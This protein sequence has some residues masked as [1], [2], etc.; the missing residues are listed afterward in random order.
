MRVVVIG[1]GP[2]GTRCA[3][4]VSCLPGAVVTLLGEE[5]G[6]P[7]DRVALSKY[8]AGDIAADELITHDGAALREAGIDHRPGLRAT[9]IDRD[10]RVVHTQDGSVLPYDKLVLALGAT[11]VR[12]PMPGIDLPGVLAYR[13]R[14]DVDAMLRAAQSGGAAVVIGG[15][16]LGLEAAAGLARRGM[17]VTVL[18]AVDRLMERQLDPGAAARLRAHLQTL[19]VA[20]LLAARS[21]RI[22]GT[23]RAA[24]V[25]LADGARIAADIVVLA[26]GIRPRVDLAREAMLEIGRGILVDDAMRSSDPAILAIGECA[27]HAGQCCGLVAPALAQAEI[28]ARTLAGEVA[29]YAPSADATALKVAGAPVFSAGEIEAADADPIVLDD[30]GGDYRRLLLRNDRL[31]GAILWGDTADAGFYRDLIERGAVLGTMRAALPFGRA[32]LPDEVVP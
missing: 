31:V 26:V 13:T 15:G 6:L 19:G 23:D 8:L 5:P 4:R 1:A 28:A 12:L 11:A 16:L 2:A 32:F 30:P 24:A 7:Y 10:A 29:C 3:E 17:R 14:E 18:H 22:D 20:C 27:E 21:V 9:A 25:T